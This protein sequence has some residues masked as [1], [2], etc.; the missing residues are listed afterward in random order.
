M[1]EKFLDTLKFREL[2]LWSSSLHSRDTHSRGFGRQ[3]TGAW[4][5]I[6]QPY[7]VFLKLKVNK[8]L[9]FPNILRSTFKALTSDME[10]GVASARLCHVKSTGYPGGAGM[11]IHLDLVD[12]IHSLAFSVVPPTAVCMDL[13]IIMASFKQTNLQTMS[14]WF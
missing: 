7:Y 11:T 3:T 13:W 8:K 9:C 12:F 6:I 2:L 10:N 1:S 4:G 14:K 5:K